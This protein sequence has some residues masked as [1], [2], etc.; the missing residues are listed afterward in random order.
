MGHPKDAFSPLF[1]CFI[2]QWVSK[3][4]FGATHHTVC[5]WLHGCLSWATMTLI[6]SHVV[7][8]FT[9][10]FIFPRYEC[11]QDRK[12]LGK[13]FQ[14]CPVWSLKTRLS[15]SYQRY[16]H[17]LIN[18][19]LVI[20]I[21]QQYLAYLNMTAALTMLP[22]AKRCR[23]YPSLCLPGPKWLLSNLKLNVLL[24]FHKVGVAALCSL[25][26]HSVLLVKSKYF[27]S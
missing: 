2:H 16:H 17:H 13:F 25:A 19:C 3:P 1:G 9:D 10:W 15:R 24:R 12:I 6:L 7:S 23:H 18:R 21:L 8:D 5:R 27:S 22:P 11:V 4:V 20:T 26:W 14:S